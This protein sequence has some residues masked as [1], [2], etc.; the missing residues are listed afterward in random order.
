MMLKRYIT[1]LFISFS[2]LLNTLSQ[3]PY[4]EVYTTWEDFLD[5]FT[6]E[7]TI[8]DDVVDFLQ[9]LKEHPLNLNTVDKETLSQLPFLTE[10][11]N[12][13]PQNEFRNNNLVQKRS[14]FKASK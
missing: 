8:D 12:W 3:V 10:V 11:L 2:L 7:E 6:E 4:R 13:R 9:Q 14:T 1:L 5:S